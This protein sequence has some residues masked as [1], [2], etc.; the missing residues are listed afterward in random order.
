[1][2]KPAPDLRRELHAERKILCAIQRVVSRHA[3]VVEQPQPRDGRKARRVKIRKAPVEQ[4]VGLV[5]V[6]G[7][8]DH[9]TTVVRAHA[10]VREHTTEK[11][12]ACAEVHAAHGSGIGEKVV[13]SQRQGIVANAIEAGIA[14]GVRDSRMPRDVLQIGVERMLESDECVA[15]HGI[16]RGIER[17]PFRRM[18]TPHSSRSARRS[19]RDTRHPVPTTRPCTGRCRARWSCRT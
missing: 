8:G 19:R 10:L 5:H 7:I 2:R 13:L 1:M 16:A 9:N 4:V 14:V 15:A 11:E 6:P 18:R 3:L 17:E 12:P